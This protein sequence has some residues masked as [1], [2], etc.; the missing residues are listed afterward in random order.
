[1]LEHKPSNCNVDM[2][3]IITQQIKNKKITKIIAI[4]DRDVELLE[5]NVLSEISNA[6][7]QINI[8]QTGRSLCSDKDMYVNFTL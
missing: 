3:S 1:M 5:D 8:Y 6:E 4:T 7:T 2:L